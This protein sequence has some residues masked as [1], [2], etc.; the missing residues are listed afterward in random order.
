MV[1]NF[2]YWNFGFLRMGTTGFTS[3]AFG[4]KDKQEVI[5]TLFRSA[6]LALIISFVLILFGGGLGNIACDLMNV[7][8]S[9]IGLVYEYFIIRIWAAPASLLLFTLFGWFFGMQN[10][11]FPLA[12]DLLS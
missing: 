9:Q 3:Q 6:F 4:A 8:E 10:A 5:N 7:Q 1:F 11:I 12:Y 2:L